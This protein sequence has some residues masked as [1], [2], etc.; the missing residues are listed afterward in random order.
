LRVLILSIEFPPGPGGIATHAFQIARH[1]HNLGCQVW[2]A[3]PQ[4]FATQ[5]EV[6]AF[7]SSQPFAIH[8]YRFRKINLVEIFERLQMT[9]R[10]AK[11]FRPDVILT[12]GKQ[13]AWLGAIISRVNR[14]KLVI[15]GAGSE[16]LVK[17]YAEKML[18]QWAI[19]RASLVLFNSHFTKLL[20]IQKGYRLPSSFIVTMGADHDVFKPGLPVAQLRQKLNLQGK[21]VILTVG[22]L[23]ERK[24]QDTVIR[25]L[26]QVFTAIPQAVY[27]LAG[28]PTL[29][30]EFQQLAKE[31]GIL[32]RVLFL[33]IVSQSEL[34]YL[35]NLADIFVLVSRQSSKGEVEGFGIAVAEAAL[36]GVP[37]IVSD[38]TGLV[39][40]ILPGQTGLIVPQDSP[41]ELARTLLTLL[42]DDDL[43]F[44]MGLAARQ[45]ALQALTWEQKASE[46]Y[47]LIRQV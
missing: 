29:Q 4:A 33:G 46:L 28:L 24:A 30:A 35:Y 23:S 3:S 22:R 41:N 42:Q 9:L 27:V 44:K 25:A 1:L 10:T 45:H 21:R 40:A 19:N 47:H 39:E 34:P 18:N 12:F 26:P 37:A 20:A 14:C 5:S 43:R 32:D 31:L 36:C 8:T 7:N 2:V 6:T 13:P 15:T 38:N 11:R 16:F 17:N